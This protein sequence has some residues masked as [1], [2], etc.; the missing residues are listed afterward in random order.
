MN[1]FLHTGDDKSADLNVLLNTFV[2][3]INLKQKW[4]V[5]K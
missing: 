1:D 5:D 2:W 3:E 4:L